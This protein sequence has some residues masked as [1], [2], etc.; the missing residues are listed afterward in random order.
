MVKKPV[1]Q[2]D[3]KQDGIYFKKKNTLAKISQ[4]R[5]R[6]MNTTQ[7]IKSEIELE[8]AI[9]NDI[10][11]AINNG[12][13]F[14]DKKLALFRDLRRAAYRN[15]CPFTRLYYKPVIIRF[16]FG[17]TIEKEIIECLTESL[18]KCFIE[19]YPNYEQNDFS[20][21]KVQKISKSCL[22]YQIIVGSVPIGERQ[23]I[24]SKLRRYTSEYD[25]DNIYVSWDRKKSFEFVV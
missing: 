9:E 16:H 17:K 8:E 20:R 10:Q 6:R 15:G 7:V 14:N 4:K 25:M 24:H 3:R 23:T 22:E 19:L 1:N 13:I 18:K 11:K 5:T 12:T 21:A 2:L